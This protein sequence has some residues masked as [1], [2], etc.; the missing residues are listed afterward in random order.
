MSRLAARFALHVAIA[1]ICSITLR[2]YVR[3]QRLPHSLATS[4]ACKSLDF[5]LDR[6]M[7]G[8]PSA[9]N[10]THRG[11][12][13]GEILIAA[14]IVQHSVVIPKKTILGHDLG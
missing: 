9:Y 10:L 4:N 11:R 2:L 3:F 5:A 14:V 8:F 1:T 6:L 13:G 7:V 12:W